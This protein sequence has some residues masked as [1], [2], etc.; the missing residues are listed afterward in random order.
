MFVT[1]FRGTSLSVFNPR[2]GIWQQTWVDTSGNYWH[3]TGEFKDGQM[4]FG[5]EDTVDGRLV[6]LRMVFY[7]ISRDELDWNWERS[8]DGGRT[9][10]LRWKLH[11]RR[12]S[13]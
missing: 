6:S 11:Y 5:T 13:G 2:I 4:E 8:D 7:N 12:K 9:W 10:E 1:R 3:F